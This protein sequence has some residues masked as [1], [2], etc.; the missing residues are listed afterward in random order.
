MT[1][2]TMEFQAETRQLLDLMIHSLYRHKEIFLRELI[3]NSSDAL[4]KVRFEA[5]TDAELLGDDDDLRIRLEPDGEAKTLTITDN[6]IGMSHDEV[7]Q[8]LGTIARSGTREFLSALSEA[9]E[10]KTSAPEL[11]GQ[12]GVGFYSAFMVADRVVVETRRADLPAS[13][14]VRWTSTGDGSFEIETVDRAERGTRITLHLKEKGDEGEEIP[15]VT[16]EWGLRAVVKKYSD[17]VQWPIRMDVERKEG[18]GDAE[19]TVTKT[20]TLNSMKPLWTRSPNEVKEEEHA[21][22]YKQFAHDWEPPARTIHFKAEGT[23]E[24]TALLYVPS[25]KPLMMAESD[26]GKSKLSLYVKRV[27]I[28]DDC[29]ELLPPWL[30]FV[31][32]LVDSSDLPLNVSRE[33]LQHTRQMTPIRKRLVSK[34]LDT[35]KSWLDDDREGY[36]KI[37][38]EFGPLLKEGIY[39]EDDETKFKVAEACL[40]RSTRGDGLVSLDEVI[41]KMPKEQEAIYWL[42]GPDLE[43]LKRSPHLEAFAARGYEVL[44]LTDPVDEFAMQR[45]TEFDGKPIQAV[46][47]GDIDLA[48]DEEKAARDEKAKELQPLI[49]AVK[50]KLGDAVSDVRFSSRLKESPAVLVTGENDMSPHMARMLRGMDRAV[51]ESK[52]ILELNPAHALVTRMEKLRDGSEARFGDFCELVYAQALL[53]EGT[54]LKDPTRFNQL[55]TTLMVGDAAT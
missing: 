13:E 36:E 26:R 27:F 47:K 33:T 35:F 42:A 32:G 1:T 21:E 50:E 46:D 6:G 9:K 3:S 14:A 17:F 16:T 30:R 15:D 52:R 54:P 5:L 8:N 39:G 53:A 22:F 19:T 44:L 18:E 45:L 2:Q 31:R 12:F 38:G 55:V 11:I 41:E 49:D 34:L 28:A 7:V 40:F 20:E 43:T 23:L 48:D 25:H 37:W 4:D 10:K 51:P 24:Y 29:D